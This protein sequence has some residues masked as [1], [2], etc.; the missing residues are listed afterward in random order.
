MTT[1]TKAKPAGQTA[2]KTAKTP[3]SRKSTMATAGKTTVKTVRSASA[4]KAAPLAAEQ[5]VTATPAAKTASPTVVEA[6][7]TVI[8]GPVMRKKELVDTIVTRSGLKKKDVKPTVEAM[9]AVLGEALADGRELILPPLGR[10]M[11][12]KERKTAN[13]RV[14]IAKIR[15]S[16]LAANKAQADSGSTAP[17]EKPK[18]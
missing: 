16:D 11:V 12:R 17:S 2:S 1:A 6:P 9:L 13:G 10:M 8:K 14:L 4:A 5:K 15:Q 7:Q 18:K 3:A